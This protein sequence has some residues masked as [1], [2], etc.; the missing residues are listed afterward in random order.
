MRIMAIDYGDAHTGIAISDPTGLLAGFTTVINAYRPDR[1]TEQIALLA[2]E[3]GV[4]LEIRRVP[5]EHAENI[6]KLF[7]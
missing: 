3:H 5:T 2:K 1:V 6:E 7:K 4:E